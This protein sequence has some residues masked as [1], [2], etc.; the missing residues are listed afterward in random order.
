MVLKAS[1]IS[2]KKGK[3]QPFDYVSYADLVML[4]D[5]EKE[6]EEENE[7]KIIEEMRQFESE[8]R[9]MWKYVNAGCNWKSFGYSGG[10]CSPR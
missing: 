3:V 9:S 7:R 10:R 4:M 8:E 1:V 2:A 6:R 5:D